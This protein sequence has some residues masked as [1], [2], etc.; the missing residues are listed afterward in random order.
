MKL[1]P[2]IVLSLA[3]AA[4]ASEPRPW[5]FPPAPGESFL[6]YS[7]R[8]MRAEALLFCGGDAACADAQ[9][10]ARDRLSAVDSAAA[11][12]AR[13]TVFTV[14]GDSIVQRR[15]V[16]GPGPIGMVASEAVTAAR[17]ASMTDHRPH[18]RTDFVAALA[19][20]PDELAARGVAVDWACIE[21]RRDLSCFSGL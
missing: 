12:P 16:G 15:E 1:A 9:E 10:A 5:E 2:A 7:R 6:D 18:P 17:V 13:R 21:E 11:P 14:E 4:C 3:L 8:Q 19:R 20:L